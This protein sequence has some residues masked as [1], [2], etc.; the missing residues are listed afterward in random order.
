MQ[1]SIPD[2]IALLAA[3][4]AVGAAVASVFIVRRGADADLKGD[5]NELTRLVERL[6]KEYRREK[7]RR[8]RH[9][10]KV[11]SDGAE[12]S[13]ELTA[14]PPELVQ[15]ATAGYPATAGGK[16]ALRRRVGALRR[17]Q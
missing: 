5:V 3:L 14:G 13:A 12:A 11:G 7:M 2:L 16:E 17:S 8:V 15:A 10:E 1:A 6:D 4:V 9:G